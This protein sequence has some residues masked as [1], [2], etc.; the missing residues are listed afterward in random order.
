MVRRDDESRAR[1]TPEVW[2]STAATRSREEL[3][4]RVGG[5]LAHC[6]RSLRETSVALEHEARR[7]ESV[8][9]SHGQQADMLEQELAR[10]VVVASAE[11]QATRTR[12]VSSTSLPG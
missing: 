11:A 8:A 2:S 4:D 7:L 5:W 6:A 12:S 9:W 10:Q 3:V 1:H